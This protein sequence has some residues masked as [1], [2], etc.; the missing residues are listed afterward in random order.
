M[1]REPAAAFEED[2]ESHERSFQATIDLP[3]NFEIEA[4]SE[5]IARAIADER[6]FTVWSMILEAVKGWRAAGVWPRSTY[7]GD[8]YDDT[9]VEEVTA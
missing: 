4:E 2:P 8:R 9:D 1:N 7:V 5:E 6:F 3:I